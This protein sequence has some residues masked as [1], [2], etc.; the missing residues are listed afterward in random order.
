MLIIAIP[1]SCSTSLLATL[2][3]L[4]SIPAQQIDLQMDRSLD[5]YKVLSEIHF[6]QGQLNRQLV[7]RFTAKNKFFKQHILPTENN[8]HLLQGRPKVVLLREPE[9]ILLSYRRTVKAGMRSK[10]P[11]KSTGHVRQLMAGCHTNADWLERAREIGLVDE[12][13]RFYE[14]WAGN[15]DEQLVIH[16]D[17]LV[18]RPGAIVNEIE[19]YFGLPRSSNVT[20]SK[21]RYT[22]SVWQNLR[23]KMGHVGGSTRWMPS[24]GPLKD[25]PAE[26]APPHRR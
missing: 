17:D 18:Q 23:R 24:V 20:L 16:F 22:R 15:D 3:R 21:E 9:H 1:K 11:N 6:D 5:D 10:D 8:R 14:G 13:T 12:L 25:R 19:D 26:I 2:G 4:H 7:R